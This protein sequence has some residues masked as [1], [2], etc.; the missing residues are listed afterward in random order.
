ME[1]FSELEKNTFVPPKQILVIKRTNV[2]YEQYWSEEK[3]RFG[4]LLE[5]TIYDGKTLPEICNE[6]AE[7]IDYREVIGVK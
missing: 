5:A 6:Y 3:N 2:D 1:T 4:P 7:M